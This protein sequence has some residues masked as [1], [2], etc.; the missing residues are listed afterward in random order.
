MDKGGCPVCGDTERINF[1]GYPEISLKA[2]SLI[3]CE[4]NIVR[5]EVC[6]FYFRLTG[7]FF[8]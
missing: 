4:Y 3:N 1:A 2:K 7:N 8:F 5:C 6:R